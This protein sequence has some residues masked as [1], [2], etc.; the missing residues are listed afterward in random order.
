MIS[1]N[2][3]TYLAMRSA[4]QAAIAV[5]GLDASVGTGDD[6]EVIINKPVQRDDIPYKG[7]VD[8]VLTRQ[9]DVYG[10]T[11]LAAMQLSDVV[12]ERLSE[13]S[14]GSHRLDLSAYDLRTVAQNLDA[15]SGTEE[16]TDT[17]TRHRYIH[18]FFMRVRPVAVA[19]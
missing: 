7:V 3:P 13:R 16:V 18:R 1:A 11:E 10:T 19:A 17:G 12:V 8:A 14:D 15:G 2:K 9:V 4:L 5:A 6:D